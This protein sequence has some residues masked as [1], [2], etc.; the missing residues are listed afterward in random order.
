M[1]I[2]IHYILLFSLGVFLFSSCAKDNYDAPGTLFKGALTYKGDTVRVERNQ[3]YFQLFEPGW[4]LDMKSNPINVN[5]SQDGVFSALLFNATYKLVLPA[6]QGPYL[7]QDTTTLAL[8]GNKTMNIEVTPYYLVRNASFTSSGRTVTATCSLEKIVT[9]ANAK[10]VERVTLYV[11]RTCYSDPGNY[12]SSVNG[13]FANL[14]SISISA[15]VPIF[16]NLQNPLPDQK[17][18]Y[19]RIGVKI[20]GV[21]DMIFSPVKMVTIQ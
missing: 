6:G 1:K 12:L 11:G 8:T 4:Q 20:Q 5:V 16:A 10:N 13:S 15:D 3:V 14:S 2:K 7:P 21:E 18:V 19:A 17:Y 9:D